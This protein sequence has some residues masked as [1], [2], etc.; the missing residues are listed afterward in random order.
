[1]ADQSDPVCSVRNLDTHSPTTPDPDKMSFRHA[2]PPECFQ[3]LPLPQVTSRLF[4]A[5]VASG[6]ALQLHDREHL[7]DQGT[8]LFLRQG[9]NYGL[10]RFLG[11]LVCSILSPNMLELTGCT[12][13]ERRHFPPH[14]KRRPRQVPDKLSADQN[15]GGGLPGRILYCHIQVRAQRELLVGCTPGRGR[16]AARRVD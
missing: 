11:I 13:T 9:T 12:R 1:M 5:I 2:F 3:V 15:M 14:R 16:K 6:S 7:R 10:N 8:T 4:E